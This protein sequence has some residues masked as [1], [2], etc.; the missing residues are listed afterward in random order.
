MAL[1]IKAKHVGKRKQ[2]YFEILHTGDLH[3]G[4]CRTAFSY[5]D[6]HRILFQEMIDIVA[7]KIG[8]GIKMVVVIAGDLAD[9]KTITEDERNLMLWFVIELTRLGAHIVII[10]GNHD[11]YN[12]DGVTMIHPLHLMQSLC[13]KTLHVVVDNPAVVNINDLDVSFLCVPCQQD[14]TTKKLRKILTGL[15]SQATCS[16]R[17]G[18]IHEAI[19]GSI[20]SDHHTMSTDCDIPENDLDGILA[21]DIHRQQRI[22]NR[23][24]YCG[25]PLQTKSDEDL[26]KGVLIWKAGVDDPEPWMLK[27]VPRIYNVVSEKKLRKLEGTKHTVNYVGTKRVISDAVNVRIKQNLKSITRKA[28]KA[29]VEE[30]LLEV[31]ENVIEGLDEF[32][33]RA[34]LT[35]DEI[36]EGIAMADAE[37]GR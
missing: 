6:R 31:T 32:L 20:S 18:V 19:N 1:K 2:N 30:A 5:L 35:P 9:R 3:T 29:D 36:T 23:A 34:G 33:K 13:P 14:L 10:N 37:K 17:Y 11:F 26:D 12:E 22:G 8:D 7:K 24:W 15:E 27:S 16:R 4:C 25:S 21:G 28:V